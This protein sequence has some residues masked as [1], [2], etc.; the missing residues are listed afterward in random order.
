MPDLASLSAE[1]IK[2]RVLPGIKIHVRLAGNMQ[3]FMIDLTL[4]AI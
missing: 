1:T 4:E 2:S 3:E